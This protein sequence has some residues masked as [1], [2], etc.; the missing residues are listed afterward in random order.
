MG[1]KPDTKAGFSLDEI[2]AL[3]RKALKLPETEFLRVAP[4][5]KGGSARSYFRIS[6]GQH[7]DSRLR[8]TEEK[9]SAVP[10]TLNRARNDK[11]R[12]TAILMRYDKTREENNYYAPIAE[13]LFKIA[14]SA[15]RILHHDPGQGVVL[16]EDLGGEDLWSFRNE[17]WDVRR[18]FYVQT[19]ALIHRLHSYPLNEFPAE[20]VPLMAGFSPAYY[21][22]EREYFLD[23]FVAAVC[24]IEMDRMERRALEEEWSRLAERLDLQPKCLIHRDLQSQNIMIRNS[25]PVLI[26]FQ[27]MRIGSPLYDLGSLLYDPY[28]AFTDGERLEL[29]HHYY[30]LAERNQDWEAY[31]EMFLLASAQRLMQAL[32]AYGYIGLMLKKEEFLGHIPNGMANL[33]DA[34]VKSG[35]LP[36]LESLCRRC[37]STLSP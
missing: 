4:I 37:I 12:G 1:I 6:Y 11:G 34:A 17:T 8:Q 31:H 5:A 36:C 22:W 28:V 30:N 19:L 15:P 23:H 7:P 21:R 27:G 20:G 35:R 10:E 14:V 29:L 2:E 13:F 25:Q 24:R 9:I 3:A 32:G 33:L 18:T 16:V 26:D